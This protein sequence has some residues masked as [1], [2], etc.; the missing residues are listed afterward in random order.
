MFPERY[1]SWLVLLLFPLSPVLL[2]PPLRLILS[3]SST[4]T[5]EVS[6]LPASRAEMSASALLSSRISNSK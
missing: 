5:R 6:L 1:G 3:G 4:T 2:M